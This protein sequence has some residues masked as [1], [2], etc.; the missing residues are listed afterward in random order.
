MGRNAS[1]MRR[2][3]AALASL[4]ST[5]KTLPTTLAVDVASRAGPALTGLTQEAN[6]S[7]RGV[8]GEA[9]PIGADGKQLTLHRTGAVAGSLEFLA[10]GTMVRARLPEK[11]AKYLVGEY[12]ILPNG[13]LPA[14]WR[15]KLDA[16]VK[17]TKVSL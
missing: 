7:R 3:N 14:G 17:E 8:Y 15:T 10:T 16:L 6:A 13:A 11:Y 9:Y 2:G 1:A 4:K 12:N 5:L